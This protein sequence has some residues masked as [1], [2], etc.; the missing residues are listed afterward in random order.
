LFVGVFF[1]CFFFFWVFGSVWVGG[2]G[3]G[4]W[5]GRE[6]ERVL[7]CCTYKGNHPRREHD[8]FILYSH[9]IDIDVFGIVGL[10]TMKQI[11]L[12]PFK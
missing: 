1:C 6:S 7:R 5:G 4:G 9:G 8:R 12:S 3:G 2:G 10:Q 11:M